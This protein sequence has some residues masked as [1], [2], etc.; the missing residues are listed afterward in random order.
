MLWK[1]HSERVLGI[2]IGENFKVASPVIVSNKI[3]HVSSRNSLNGFTEMLLA[4]KESL[5]E[6]SGLPL[7]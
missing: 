6:A 1:K 2:M 3:P 7:K 4:L 5:T